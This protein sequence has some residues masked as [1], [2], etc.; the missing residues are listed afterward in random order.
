MTTNEDMYMKGWEEDIPKMSTEELTLILSKEDDCNSKYI[1]IVKEELAKRPSLIEPIKDTVEDAE[2]E[3]EEQQDDKSEMPFPLWLIA[4]FIGLA[5]VGSLRNWNVPMFILS[6]YC[7]WL[8][9]YK[10]ENSIYVAQAIII[11]NLCVYIMSLLLGD[12][13]YRMVG[14]LLFAIIGISLNLGC[15]YYLSNSESV[16]K[17]KPKEI[18]YMKNLDYFLIALP[19]IFYLIGLL[20]LL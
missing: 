11:I 20:T 9:I 2:R 15:Y 10:K 12:A 7:V 5:G 14:W 1:D 6:M 4:L 8:F 13:E 19:V 16:D 17:F 3:N 18:R